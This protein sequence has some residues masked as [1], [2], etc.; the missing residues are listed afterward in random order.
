MLWKMQNGKNG[1]RKMGF[2]N[3]GLNFGTLKQDMFC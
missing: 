1:L 2:K 3:K